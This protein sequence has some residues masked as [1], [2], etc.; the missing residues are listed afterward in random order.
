MATESIAC[1]LCQ[2]K[3]HSLFYKDQHRE[4]FR[5]SVCS[6]VFVPSQYHLTESEEKLRYD[7]HNNDPQDSHYRE[8]LSQLTLPLEELIPGQSI[9]LDFGSGPGPTL[10]LMLEEKGYQVDLYDKYY[11]KD[12]SVFNTE[13]DFITLT[14]V[15]EHLS[16]PI[17]ELERL[18]SILKPGGCIAIM[19]QTMK[20]EIDFS[21]WYYKNDPSHIG[22][23][24]QES[25]IFLANHLE[26]EVNFHSDRVI[27]FINN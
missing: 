26:L 23:Y 4:Y 7:T 13:F 19:T 8:F 12:E 11:A 14:E 22:F 17:F 18:T 2:S 15:I 24:N 21:K 3:N 5:C 9:G 10:S 6:F 20:Q 25:F 16:D 1:P 27:F